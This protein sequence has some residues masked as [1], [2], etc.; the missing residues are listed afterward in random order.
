MAG[1]DSALRNILVLKTGVSAISQK[2]LKCLRDF[3]KVR[4]ASENFWEVLEK[5]NIYSRSCCKRL[6]TAGTVLSP[7]SAMVVVFL[8]APEPRF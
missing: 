5:F 6:E 8:D 1:N 2:T 3:K 4:K 7:E